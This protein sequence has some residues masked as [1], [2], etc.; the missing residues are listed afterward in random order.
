MNT[1]FNRWA[2][3]GLNY[4]AMNGFNFTDYSG[5]WNPKVH[6]KMLKDNI[7]YVYQKYDSNFTCKL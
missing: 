4:Q 6:D 5:G 7:H 2:N 1:G 3:T